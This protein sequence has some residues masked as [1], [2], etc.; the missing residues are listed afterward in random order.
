MKLSIVIPRQSETRTIHQ[1]A[2][3]IGAD[4]VGD[5]GITMGGNRSRGGFRAR[6]SVVNS[7]VFR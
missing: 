3:R 1:I 6:K 4:P 7:N 5:G 2:G